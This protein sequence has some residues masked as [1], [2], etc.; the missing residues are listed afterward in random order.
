MSHDMIDKFVD[1]IAKNVE[2]YDIVCHQFPH[3]C[4][5][6]FLCVFP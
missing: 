3:V 4:N 2:F 5:I 6:L 1:Y